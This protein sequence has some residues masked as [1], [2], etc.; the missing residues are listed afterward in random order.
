MA[1]LSGVCGYARGLVLVACAGVETTRRERC[2]HRR[3]QAHM[4]A[5][6]GLHGDSR[7]T[8]TILCAKL[9][10]VRRAPMPSCER[11]APIPSCVRVCALVCRMLQA[12]FVTCWECF[13]FEAALTHEVG[14]LLGLG[15]HTLCA[16]TPRWASPMHPPQSAAMAWTAHALRTLPIHSRLCSSRFGGVGDLLLATARVEVRPLLCGLW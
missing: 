12:I 10:A 1:I 3:A 5:S 7:G 15:M 14:H 16:H 9:H 13:D 6:R 11:R 4:Q 2:G 8:R